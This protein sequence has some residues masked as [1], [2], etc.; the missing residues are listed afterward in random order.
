MAAAFAEMERIATEEGATLIH[1]Y[2][3]D[4]MVLGSATCGAEYLAQVPHLDT[5]IVPIGGGGMI[6][7]MSAAAKLINPAIEVI[8]VEPEGADSMAQSLEQGHPVTLDR[9]NTLADSLGAPKALPITFGVAQKYLDRI[10]R[11]PDSALLDGMDHLRRVLRMMAEPA[12]A[13]SLAALIGPL[14]DEMAG[15]HVGIIACGSNIGL[16]RYRDLLDKRSTL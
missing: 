10:L 7:G 16:Q 6:A 13:A 14:R 15:R 3:A 5:L 11:L 1:P 8:G 4:H 12:C 9:V 2:D